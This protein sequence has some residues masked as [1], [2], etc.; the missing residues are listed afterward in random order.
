MMTTLTAIK[1]KCKILLIPSLKLSGFYL[2]CIHCNTWI[3][4]I[5]TNGNDKLPF[6][7][8]ADG[9]TAA[10]YIAV[11]IDEP[12]YYDQFRK[13]QLQESEEYTENPIEETKQGNG[14]K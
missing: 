12:A 14:D 13:L 6:I 4:I 10:S 5:S 8:K 9:D 2:T 3:R 1:W 7:V 11:S